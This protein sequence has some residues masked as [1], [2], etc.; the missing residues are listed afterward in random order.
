MAVRNANILAARGMFEII[1]VCGCKADKIQLSQMHAE[2]PS[3]PGEW[4]R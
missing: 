2:H 4:T 3:V 1:S